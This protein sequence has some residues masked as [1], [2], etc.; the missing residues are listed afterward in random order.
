[1]L[2]RMRNG[3]IYEM[4][5]G[6]AKPE[7]SYADDLKVDIAGARTVVKVDENNLLP[8]AELQ[9]SIGKRDSQ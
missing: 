3:T 6:E 1:M 8:C 4:Q 2:N 7:N 9:F 5:E